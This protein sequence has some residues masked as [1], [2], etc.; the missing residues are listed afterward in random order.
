MN[1][2]AVA[3]ACRP[4]P[5]I[6]CLHAPGCSS[7]FRPPLPS[8]FL[9]QVSL[10]ILLLG[11]ARSRS[12]LQAATVIRS[13]DWARRPKTDLACVTKLL[14]TRAPWKK[15]AI[16]LPRT[17]NGS[18]TVKPCPDTSL[19]TSGPRRHHQLAR[20]RRPQETGH[21]QQPSGR[22]EPG[23]VSSTGPHRWQFR[24]RSEHQVG[25]H[26][27]IQRSVIVSPAWASGGAA[28]RCPAA[29]RLLRVT[30]SRAGAQGDALPCAAGGASTISFQCCWPAHY[31]YPAGHL[32]CDCSGC[33]RL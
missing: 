22:R 32:P 13:P 14:A 30:A 25:I 17:K 18:M 8:Q 24:H 28:G 5:A 11:P 2:A 4:R 3:A 6:L 21:A 9:H 1:L 7:Q 15:F 20:C 29:H 27:E 31:R 23:P 10:S 16:R 26:A 19:A 12:H 33:Q